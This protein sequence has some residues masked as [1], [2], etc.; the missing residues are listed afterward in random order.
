MTINGF[1]FNYVGE[2][3]S[4][5]ENASLEILLSTE[6]E[7]QKQQEYIKA[8]RLRHLINSRIDLIVTE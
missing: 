7:L 3:V 4:H 2:L 8:S 5:P 1:V 6:K